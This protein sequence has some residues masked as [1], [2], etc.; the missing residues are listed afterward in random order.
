[1]DRVITPV[2]SHVHQCKVILTG[3]GLKTF[4]GVHR[5]SLE[6]NEM[7]FVGRFAATLVTDYGS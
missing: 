2:Y 1:M 3:Q 5:S 6:F 7:P 4:I